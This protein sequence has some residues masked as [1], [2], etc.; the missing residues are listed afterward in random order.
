MLNDPRW[1]D[2]P[3][4]GRDDGSRDRGDDDP[5]ELERDQGEGLD[6]REHALVQSPV[7]TVPSA[8]HD[9]RGVADLR[10]LFEGDRDKV[11]IVLL[12]SPT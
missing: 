9:L 10:S 3:R 7:A 4:D 5:R 12:L 8:L 11:R 6:P 2:D 1:G